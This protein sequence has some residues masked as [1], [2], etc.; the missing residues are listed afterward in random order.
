[1]VS[2]ILPVIGVWIGPQIPEAPPCPVLASLILLMM[3]AADR[4]GTFTAR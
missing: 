4:V 2:I 1:M 3:E